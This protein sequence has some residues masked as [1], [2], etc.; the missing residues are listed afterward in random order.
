[1]DEHD[2]CWVG[3]RE[4][5]AAVDGAGA[6]PAA[7]RFDRGRAAP[8]AVL[9]SLMPL[10]ER[11]GADDQGRVEIVGPRS[12]LAQRLPTVALGGDGEVR[13]LVD[14]AEEAPHPVRC[15]AGVGEG[16]AAVPDGRRR[17]RA[18]QHDSGAFPR[19]L[20]PG[21]V[22]ASRRRAVEGGGRERQLRG[23]RSTGA[24]AASGSAIASASPTT[25]EVNAAGAKYRAAAA[26]TLSTDVAS[27]RAGCPVIQS[28][29]SPDADSADRVEAS[30]ACVAV[31][32]ASD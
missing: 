30:P 13:N 19:A 7:L 10:L 28:K 29:P 32:S 20:Q 3:A 22:G 27:S 26:E 1:M 31:E 11:H 24:R 4:V 5:L 21:L 16:E 15:L 8:R 9:V 18:D 12:E 25:T 6:G 2:H 14:H 17:T 23:H